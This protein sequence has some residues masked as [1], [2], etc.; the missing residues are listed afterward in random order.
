[1]YLSFFLDTISAKFP[2]W[3]RL[4]IDKKYGNYV[5]L[6]IDALLSISQVNNSKCFHRL[7]LPE[8]ILNLLI[9]EIFF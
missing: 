5:L 9:Y 3:L 1:M 2:R 4:L 6:K 7:D 8:K